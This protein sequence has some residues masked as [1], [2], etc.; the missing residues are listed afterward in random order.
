MTC[1]ILIGDRPV[2]RAKSAC[3]IPNSS[4]ISFKYSPGCI[5]G[6]PFLAINSIGV[7]IF[8]LKTQPPLIVNADT[9]TSF[10]S[11]IIANV[12]GKRNYSDLNLESKE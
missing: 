2:F 4:R 9:V 7:A 6:N 5:G 3:E 10:L 12:H 11:V 1:E 8:K